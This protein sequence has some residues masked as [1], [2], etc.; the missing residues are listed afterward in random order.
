MLAF[1]SALLTP[2]L[3]A[4]L[5]AHSTTAHMHL[6]QPKPLNYDG[7]SANYDWWVNESTFPCRGQLSAL[8]TAPVEATWAAGSTQTFTLAGDSPHYGGSCQVALSYDQGKTFRVLKS[9]PGSCPHRVAGENQDFTFTVPEGAPSGEALFGWSWFNREQE[10][11]HN[12]AVVEITGG[13]GAGLDH[14]PEMLVADVGNGCL[15]VRKD[16]ETQ[17]P[18]PGEDVELGDGEYPLALPEGNC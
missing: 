11:Y 10:M 12:C 16:A 3:A 4:L 15:T 2:L 13:S 9:F 14:L 8:A 1:P 18:N 17:F 5:L 6:H 7:D